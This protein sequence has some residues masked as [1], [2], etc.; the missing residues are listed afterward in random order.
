MTIKV[1]KV[2]EN[3]EFELLGE[4]KTND[5]VD[6]ELFPIGCK[7][8][9]RETTYDPEG[10]LKSEYVICAESDEELADYL[11]KS[12]SVPNSVMRDDLK[13]YFTRV[14]QEELF[15]INIIK[16]LVEICEKAGVKLS[17]KYKKLV[18]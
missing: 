16:D 6:E 3:G 12:M 14:D 13:K 5:V 15:Y 10:N 8:Q 11:S 17:D 18:R 4:H 7:Y 1:W 2:A 9:S